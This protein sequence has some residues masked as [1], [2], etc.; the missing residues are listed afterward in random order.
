MGQNKPN[1]QPLARI[2][3]LA[4]YAGV[5]VKVSVFK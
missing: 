3:G 1:R 2:R 5:K 4:V